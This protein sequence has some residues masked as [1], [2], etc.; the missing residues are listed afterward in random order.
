MKHRP[1]RVSKLI[2]EELSMIIA[3]ELN[4]NGALATITEVVVDKHLG[5]ARVMLSVIPSSKAA[6]A[7]KVANADAGN[8]QYLLMKKIQ[9][10]PLPRIRFEIDRGPEH[11]ANVEKLLLKQ[12]SESEENSAA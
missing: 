5:T 12:E 10:K 1:E 11:A 9:I 4:F 2:R 3:R 7:L 6:K 8:L